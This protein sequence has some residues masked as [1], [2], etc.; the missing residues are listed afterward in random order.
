[1]PDGI[2]VPKGALISVEKRV[3]D[4]SPDPERYRSLLRSLEGVVTVLLT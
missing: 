2:R 1:M 4:A 3:L